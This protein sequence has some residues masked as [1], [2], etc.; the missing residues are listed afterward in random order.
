MR[1]RG[2]VT[3]RVQALDR[4]LGLLVDPHPRRRVPAAKADL[5]DVHL[6][7]L[8][9][10]VGAAIGVELAATRAFVA[11]QDLFDVLD[12]FLGQVIELEEHRAVAA[13]EFLV[14]LP[15]HL[16][17]PVVALDEAFALVVGGVAAQRAGDVGAGRA[18][19]ILD[20]RVDLE[21][22][23]VRQFGPGVI[24][25]GVAVAGIGR[26]FVGAHQVARGRQA[27]AP[28]GAAAEDHR[29][30]LDHVEV[31]GAAIEAHHAVDRALFVR[32]QARADQR[33]W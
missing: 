24:G 2:H 20:Q 15:H 19:V 25:H 7:H 29:F 30:G 5:G 14:E 4:G 27:Q 6:D 23:E 28:G 13:F 33:D 17:A 8:R 22:F 1:H 32:Q 21:A 31:G 12:G 18:V 26:V 9:A 11:V 16:A 3:R 10:V